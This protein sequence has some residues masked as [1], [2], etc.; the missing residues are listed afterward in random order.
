L[1]VDTHCHLYFNLF[2]QD[3]DEVLN[4]A[5]SANLVRILN[6][7]I[8]LPT[9]QQA[10]RLAERYPECY[11]AVGLHPHDAKTWTQRSLDQVRALASHPK[12]VAIGEIGLDYYRKH[13]PRELQIT[14]FRQQLSIAAECGL[15]VVV[16]TRN[17]S[18]DDTTAIDDALDE[19]IAWQRG[20]SVYNPELAERPGVLHSYSSDLS[21]AEL[22][23]EYNFRIGI[24]GP[25]TFKK[26]DT[27]RTVVGNLPLKHLLI[28]TDA[29]FLTPHP[30]RGKRNEPAY[31]QY[32]ADKIAQV[33]NRTFDLVAEIT[34]SNAEKLFRW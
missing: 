7:G 17:A 14:V 5:R 34:T 15:P 21:F 29:P 28:E 18:A 20:L 1:L 13:A 19:L 3:L 22:A 30:Y 10:V 23:V 12:V 25:V 11:A 33:Q 32:V 4:R 8:D 31:V 2:D 6:P 24:T 27:L 16:H 26:A 9:S